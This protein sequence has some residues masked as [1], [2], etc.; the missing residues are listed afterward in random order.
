M[1]SK[2]EPGR[3]RQ[4]RADRTE[5]K[6]CGGVTR[7]DTDLGPRGLAALQLAAGLAPIPSG[8]ASGR[9]LLHLRFGGVGV[10]E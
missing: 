6:R 10:E 5:E 2:A 9:G 4:S 3:A 7:S 1:G 8:C